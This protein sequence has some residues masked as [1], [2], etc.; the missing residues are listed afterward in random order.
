MNIGSIF[1]V[2]AV[3]VAVALFVAQP[4]MER[5][6]RRLTAEAQ[7]VSAL[8]AERD[9]V[10]NALQ[11]LDF[12]YNLNKIPAED[13]PVQRA[14]LLQKGADVLKK[15]D[16]I[17]TVE[18]ASP[19]EDRVEQAVAA[20]RADLATG[21]VAPDDDDIEAMIASRRSGRKDKSGGFCPRCGKPVTAVDRFCP[22]CGK[23]L[24]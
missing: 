3:L 14:M 24:A 21:A 10:V 6:G 23:S 7:E 15:L 9:R 19:A 5:R 1:L 17:S 11:E 2:L 4:Y 20:R 22:S 13:Y 8:L 18:S 16:A 12:D